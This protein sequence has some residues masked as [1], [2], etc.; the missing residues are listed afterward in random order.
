[1]SPVTIKPNKEMVNKGGFSG[2]EKQIQILPS[3]FTF[4]CN[5]CILIL[6]KRLS[7]LSIAFVLWK[8]KTHENICE[9]FS[10]PYVELIMRYL[11]ELW[12][13]PV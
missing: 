10:H 11:A 5:H 1:M 4:I 3:L 9:V 12:E 7:Y 13:F 6:R 8:P 2:W